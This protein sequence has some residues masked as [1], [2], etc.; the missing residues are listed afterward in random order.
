MQTCAIAF[1]YGKSGTG[2]LDAEIEIYYVVLLGQL[3]VGLRVFGQLSVVLDELHDEVVFGTDALG[4]DI[5]RKV[6]QCY[7]R[8]LQ[9]LAD[10]LEACR[11][12]V[13]T[14]F[15][16]RY[17]GLFSLGLV[18]QTFAHEGAYLLCGSVLLC[19]TCVQLGLNGLALVVQLLYSVYDRL[20]IDMFLGQLAYRCLLVVA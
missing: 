1:V 12:L 16:R 3:P 7:D 11:Q 10:L 8:R 13:G 20:G 14:L 18:A 5:R 9:L 4:D 6:G 15:Q 17:F 2:E 19:Q